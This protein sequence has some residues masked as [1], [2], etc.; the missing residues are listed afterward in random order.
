MSRR[1]SIRRPTIAVGLSLL[2]G[3]TA[4]L[5]V[6]GD[7]SPESRAIKDRLK[8]QV[9]RIASL[10]VSYR[11]EATSPLKAEQLVALA[12]FRNQLFLPKD[13][14]HVA[15]KGQK[16]FH[17]QVHPERL[18]LLRPTDEFGMTPPAPVDPKSAPLVQKNQ[19]ELIKQYEQMVATMKAQKARGGPPRYTF[20]NQ[21][22]KD[23]TRAFNG[24]T[25]WMRHP[26]SDK[27]DA[28]QVWPANSE[29]DWFQATPFALATGLHVPDPTARSMVRKAQAMFR[30]ADWVSEQAYQLEEKTEVV[31]GSTCVI[32]R[33]SLN[34]LLQ[35]GLIVGELT[36]RIWLD[37]DHGLAVRQR[38]IATD[39]KVGMRWINTELKEVE[40]GLWL[41]MHCRHEQY[42]D[43]APPEW[44]Q[45]PVLIE[46]VRVT[47]IEVN[48]V[49]DDLFDMTPRESDRIEDLR[50]VLS[51]K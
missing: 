43:D 19:K 18:T 25:I 36:N 5:A 44:K 6:R 14:W 37:R 40:P 49:S 45:K 27:V 16:R 23:V 11:R 4:W 30:A 32:L 13:E 20:D 47:K 7:E 51:G 39:G 22:E 29:I 2:T 10:E 50:G 42:A 1:L 34:S 24:R 15:F 38:E 8:M 46:D 28:Y 21:P 26:E 35:P 17:R 31:D 3:L 12:Q 33:G 48:K 41:P 9:E